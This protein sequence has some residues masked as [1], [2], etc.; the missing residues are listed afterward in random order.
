MSLEIFS[1]WNAVE[2]WPTF[3]TH[4]LP[5]L[6]QGSTSPS[7]Y[8]AY[9]LETWSY[10]SYVL[11][12]CPQ[13]QPM[14]IEFVSTWLALQSTGQPGAFSIKGNQNVVFLDALDGGH[15]VLSA[16]YGLSYYRPKFYVW[17]VLAWRHPRKGVWPDWGTYRE[18][19]T[20][21]LFPV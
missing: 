8:G 14:P 18:K 17:T 2:V 3:H 7:S 10:D 20:R 13:L 1:D 6:V 5:A 15:Y 19:G 9:E 16:R 4:V 21:Y 11:E 12:R